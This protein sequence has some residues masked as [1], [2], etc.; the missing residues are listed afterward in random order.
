MNVLYNIWAR[1]KWVVIVAVIAVAALIYYY[2]VLR[3]K[4]TG[5]TAIPGQ[6]AIDALDE[7]YYQQMLG[8]IQAKA[9]DQWGW[10]APGISLFFPGGSRANWPGLVPDVAGKT[11]KTE[12][13]TIATNMLGGTGTWDTDGSIAV[14]N[15]YQE[16]LG[17]A[18]LAL[19]A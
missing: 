18:R 12:R 15:L 5:Q 1:H 17:K 13:L 10:F 6:Y 4:Q 2:L 3:P 11:S 14:W 19:T 8:L 7:Q 16:Y 9:P